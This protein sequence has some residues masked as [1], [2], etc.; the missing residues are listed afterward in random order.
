MSAT[1][2]SRPVSTGTV[3]PVLGAA[4]FCHML[5]DMMQAL[6]PAVYPILR[7]D[8]NLTFAQVGILTLVYQITASIL[9]PLIGFY[10]D[11]RPQPYLLPFAMLSR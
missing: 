1:T 9:Q 8:F 4:S 7:G 2:Q 10:T 3:I 5:N 6:L 11:T